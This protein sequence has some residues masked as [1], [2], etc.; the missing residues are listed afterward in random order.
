M[1]NK[2]QSGPRVA[3]IV[4]P[5]LSGKTTF[6]ESILAS[7]GAIHRKGNMRDGNTVGDSLPEAR[8]RNMSTELNVVSATYLDEQWTFLDCPGSVELAQDSLYAIMVADVAVV[9]AEPTPDKAIGLS[10]ILKAL[11]DN[12]VPHMIFINK[13][14][15]PDTS[16]RKTFEA[17][18]TVSSRPLVLRE[19]PIR[20][21]NNISGHVDLVSERAF[22]WQEGKPSEL[23]ALPD[24]MSTSESDARAG[25]LESLADFDDTLLEELLED[26]VPSSDEV[27]ANLT[28]DLQ[29]DLIVPVFFGSV[30]HDNGVTRILKALRHETAEVDAVKHR[31][32]VN[33][34][35]VS[36]QA[37][38]VVHAGQIGK[39]TLARV[40][41]GEVKDG[42]S[43]NGERI[44]GLYHMN[45][46][47]HDKLTKAV[48]GDV[49]ALGRLENVTAG[50]VLNE[51]GG[52]R[53]ALWPAPLT[54]LFSIALHA[55]D[56]GN[57]VKM[58]S[59]VNKVVEEDPALSSTHDP[60]TG[61]YLL[62][63]Q[64]EIHL[65]IALDRLK[66][67]YG[68][69]IT[70]ER[71]QVPYKETIRKP[72]SQHAR[73]KKQSGGHGEFGDVHLDIKPLP[74][75]TGFDF[76][77]SITGGVVPKQYI[78]AVQHGVKEYLVRGPLGFPVVD[79]AV[80]L[81]DGQFHAVD[82]SE[83]AF[84][85]AAQQ[86]MREGMPN[87]SPVLL[88]PIC[89]VTISMPNDFTSNIQRLVSGRRGTILGFEAK[90]AWDGWDEVQANIPQSEMHDL[91]IELRS[92]T[93]GVGTFE[94]A[95]DHLQELSGRQ[96]DDAVAQRAVAR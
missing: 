31:L 87:C 18:Q 11:E 20:D 50:D 63:G 72:A 7:A 17:L 24:D 82:S 1:T 42:M 54:P 9:V 59:A 55:K 23:I 62:W 83:M 51:D 3:A 80:S 25:M 60:D 22:R 85:K 70:A 67:R 69:E 84:K 46:Q 39:L 19:V 52:G 56:R 73:H 26:V 4:G 10:P 5:Y 32:D 78:P 12:G 15:H 74:R 29:H 96:A 86:A 8:A 30:E 88:E 28:K 81:T 58:S 64:G 41:A 77:D 49:V 37:F 57:D 91:I 36:A 68:L 6:L 16:V 93:Q 71:P 43:L 21:G 53:S 89:M 45:G 79:V 61:E 27:Y 76:S 33:G 65:N 90:A 38:K 75:G 94:W 48:A 92:M 95:F 66:N 34:D 35:P 40:M 44:S 47:K 13:M 2:A 14:D